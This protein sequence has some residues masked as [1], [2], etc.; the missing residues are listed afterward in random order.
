MSIKFN[1]TAHK[2]MWIWLARNPKKYK[3]AWPGWKHNGGPY[4][5]VQCACFA[6]EYDLKA[7]HGLGSCK[8]C[9]LIWYKDPAFTMSCTY[10]YMGL[11]IRWC[12]AKESHNYKLASKL[13][14]RIAHLKVREG[15]ECE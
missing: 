8:E 7:T 12:D 13:A 14:W 9:P 3:E 5:L 6:C 10:P 1:Y 15:V 4:H 2:E 11:F